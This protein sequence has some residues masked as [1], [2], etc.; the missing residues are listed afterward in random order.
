MGRDEFS[1]DSFELIKNQKPTENII[2][3]QKFALSNTAYLHEMRHFFDCFGT[4]SG[5]NLFNHFAQ[6]LSDFVEVSD[7]M[8]KEGLHWKLPLMSWLYEDSCPKFVRKFIRKAIVLKNAN[9]KFNKPFEPILVE[10]T[11][12][13][14][15]VTL[16]YHDTG[17]VQAFPYAV[18][19]IKGGENIDWNNKKFSTYLMP[20]GFETLIEGNALAIQRSFFQGLSNDNDEFILKRLTAGKIGNVPVPTSY[21]VTD[22]LIS[23]YLRSKNQPTFKRD[24]ILALTDMTLAQGWIEEVELEMEGATAMSI[25]QVDDLFISNLHE[26]KINE[27]VNGNVSYPQSFTNAYQSLLDELKKIPKPENVNP[28]DSTPLKSITIIRRFVVHNIVIPL[29]EE[30]L[31]TNHKAFSTYNGFIELLQKFS[32]PPFLVTKDGVKTNNV[33]EFVYQAWWH[34]IM[35]GQKVT[36]LMSNED[37]LRCPRAN[38]LF[39]GSSQNL[40]FGSTCRNNIKRKCGEWFSGNS[41][42]QPSCL[43]S[44]GIKY[45]R[46]K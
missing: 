34:F 10:G 20:L 24:S 42:K 27:L 15:F 32:Y 21:Y 8:S 12:D 11:T 26:A 3:Q 14:Y 23:K 29:L 1:I 36:H 2:E 9:A 30:R 18:T 38:P 4:Y 13:K 31:A 16:P 39:A 7:R 41:M 22:L 44:E 46:F 6:L 28:N 5:Y 35:I 40:A 43:F 45:F 33:P 17:E 19:S 37:I 25:D